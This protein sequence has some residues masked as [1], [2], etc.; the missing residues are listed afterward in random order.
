MYRICILI[1][2]LLFSVSCTEVQ[3]DLLY[4]G[5][6]DIFSDDFHL[7][8]LS[9]H[10]M[11]VDQRNLD[12]Y[13]F[14]GCILRRWYY[15]TLWRYRNNTWTLLY[16]D[17][18]TMFVRGGSQGPGSRCGHG[19]AIM[20]DFLYVFGGYGSNI[21]G[22]IG[23]L[24]DL[25]RY[26]ISTGEWI[27]LGGRDSVDV[28]NDY[29]TPLP[30][31]RYSMNIVVQSD[32]T[33]WLFGGSAENTH[34]N[35]L[36][37]YKGYWE[38]ISGGKKIV[39]DIENNV[40]SSRLGFGMCLDSKDQIWIYGGYGYSTSPKATLLGDLWMFNGTW[41]HIDTNG[42]IPR[43]R[44]SP[45]M[46]IDKNDTIYI[47]GG[48][49]SSGIVDS[50]HV[51]KNNTFGVLYGSDDQAN[52]FGVYKGDFVFPGSRGSAA[53]ASYG[54]DII[55]FGGI[56]FSN[57]SYGSLNELWLF[58]F[59]NQRK[60]RDSFYVR[61]FINCVE[62][63]DNRTTAYLGYN[64]EVPFSLC[65]YSTFTVDDVLSG[66]DICF[67]TGKRNFQFKKSF[68]SH[69]FWLLN[70]SV[71]GIDSLL[72][73][74]YLCPDW[75]T[76]LLLFKDDVPSLDEIM[77]ITSSLL[78]IS[79]DKIEV[80]VSGSEIRVKVTLNNHVSRSDIIEVLGDPNTDLF[81]SA[82]FNTTVVVYLEDTGREKYDTENSETFEIEEDGF[83]RY[84]EIIV[85][86][87]LILFI[88]LFFLFFFSQIKFCRQS[89]CN[90]KKTS[91][92]IDGA[93]KAQ[94]ISLDI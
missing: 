45:S 91:G 21:G 78:N 9:F 46:T 13:V 80:F 7:G 64:N 32:H 69:L 42:S 67:K 3:W 47:H 38:L 36:W 18:S 59:D 33:L 63:R 11:V 19:F 5:D 48:W 93:M 61:P 34:Y 37:K 31:G 89:F 53:I 14:G 55:M 6:V 40:I 43:A 41:I 79:R 30:G 77:N 87:V 94:V 28:D 10:G 88:I 35:E 75:I 49:T 51:Y 23:L 68:N 4:G 24:S 72:V 1:S 25:W 58:S 62:Q 17:M 57:D 76:F 60:E 84:T 83:G 52:I 82:A 8:S 71:V 92:N 54:S 29:G 85:A 44:Y 81:V 2:F 66:V 15:N 73:S 22:S 12:V 27:F 65:M 39:S 90:T 50:L 86:S 70:G 20:G 56:G 74:E 16:G 26:T